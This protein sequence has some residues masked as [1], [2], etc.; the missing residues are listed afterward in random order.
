MTVVNIKSKTE[1]SFVNNA[2]DGEFQ[3]DGG[4]KQWKNIKLKLFA[5]NLMR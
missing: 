1:T 3:I 4:S 5:F 2:E